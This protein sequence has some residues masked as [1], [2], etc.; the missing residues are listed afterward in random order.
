MRV[1]KKFG[2]TATILR[3]YVSGSP[4]AGRFAKLLDLGLR[5]AHSA[6]VKIVGSAIR[7]QFF[8]PDV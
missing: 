2:E 5:A 4:A 8:S 1:E 7:F 3:D 6:V